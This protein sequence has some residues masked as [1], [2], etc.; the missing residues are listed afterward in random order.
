[1]DTLFQT[2]TMVKILRDQG[3][4]A[5]ARRLQEVLARKKADSGASVSVGEWKDPE[6]AWIEELQTW[7]LKL[8]ETKHGIR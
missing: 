4:E 6:V 5:G 3:D 7:L 2:P 1:M 8:K